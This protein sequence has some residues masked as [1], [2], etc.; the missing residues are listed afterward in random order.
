[1]SNGAT[2]A[3]SNDSPLRTTYSYVPWCKFIGLFV[4]VD[5]FVKHSTKLNFE[6]HLQR[7]GEKWTDG[8]SLRT[9]R[10]GDQIPVW[11][12]FSA[13]VQT[14]PEAH[15]ASYTM[16]TGSLPGVKR[17]RR[18]V[19]HPPASSAEVKKTVQLYLYSPLWAFVAFSSVNFTFNNHYFLTSHT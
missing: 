9:G 18:G 2:F 4:F 5:Q 10:S 15:P 16:G 8:N 1:V 12:R 3:W 19:D 14:G 11:A 17:P 13:P 7:Y 6:L